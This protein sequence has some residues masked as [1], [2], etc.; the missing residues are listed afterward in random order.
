MLRRVTGKVVGVRYRLVFA[1]GAGR[2]GVQAWPQQAALADDPFFVTFPGYGAQPP[3]PTDINAWADTLLAASAE[4]VHLIAHSYGAIA[5]VLAA[6]RR[7]AWCRSLLFFEPAL[8]SLARG[9]VSIEHHINRLT[10]VVTEAPSLDAATFWVQWSTAMTGTAPDA[11]T[12]P[13]DLA[14][15]ERLRL[16]APPWTF[17]VPT[18]VFAEVESLV[19]TAGWN[20]EYEDI[21]TAMV[22]LGAQHQQLLGR[23]HRLIDDPAATQLIHDWVSAHDSK[24]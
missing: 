21:A 19:V 9:C 17:E 15:A 3:Q 6:S 13:A 8:Y 18:A 24:N 20:Q 12:A 5:S 16:L 14:T 22:R 23:G 2:A 10:P 4:P 11:A 1:H 7:P